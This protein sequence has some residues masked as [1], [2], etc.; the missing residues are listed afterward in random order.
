MNQF[1]KSMRVSPAIF[2]LLLLLPS[3]A[4]A[5]FFMGHGKG[6]EHRKEKMEQRIQQIYDQLNL[7]EE[8]KR[9]LAD[10][11]S[12]HKAAKKEVSNEL[13]TAMQSMGEELKKKDLDM[14]TINAIHARMKNLRGRMADERFNAILGVRK[15][16]T[17]EQFA[18]FM[19]L[20]D[21]K[22]DNKPE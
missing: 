15:I 12:K 1:I 22:K 5:D 8:Q 3:A 7:N 21:R 20:M 16:L 17:Q 11:K 4:R 6:D 18:R 9:L 10:N 19:D 2:T 14:G 13:K